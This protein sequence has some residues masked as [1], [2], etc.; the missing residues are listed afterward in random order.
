MKICL[1]CLRNE[2][3]SLVLIELLFTHCLHVYYKGVRINS[4]FISED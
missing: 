3:A 4:C 2:T 1:L